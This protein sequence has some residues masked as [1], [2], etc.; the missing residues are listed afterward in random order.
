MHSQQNI[1]KKY[2]VVLLTTYPLISSYTHNGD[3]TLQS[4]SGGQRT[5]SCLGRFNA[6][7]G[8]R[9]A[10][11]WVYTRA[12]PKAEVKRKLYCSCQENGTWFLSRPHRTPIPV[13]VRSKSKA[14]SLLI[15]GITGCKPG[16]VMAVRLLCLLCR[17]RPL[18]RA[19]HSSRGKSYQVCVCVCVSN[20]VWSRNLKSEA[21]WARI[22]GLLR[23]KRE[24]VDQ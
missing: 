22:G 11:G 21:T 13:I 10:W 24:R 9:Y 8:P 16:M 3:D 2:T 17:L 1:K 18:R 14:H 5:N 12:G 6:R 4:R 7:K 20:C 23:H 15:A 19:D